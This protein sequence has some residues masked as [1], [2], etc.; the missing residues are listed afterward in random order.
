MKVLNLQCVQSHDFEGWFSSEDDF[1]SQLAHGLL[2]CPVCGDRQIHKMP[3]APRLNLGTALIETA[4]TPP[5]QAD[6]PAVSAP[7][8]QA[9]QAAWLRVAREAMKHSEDVGDA[10]AEEARR[11]HRG[12]APERG[13]RGHTS[14]AEA[15][16]LMEE[17]V[18]VM[19]L[20]A[21]SK[22]TLQ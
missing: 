21:L 20:P 14:V 9:W 1:Q 19:P 11:I 13:I 6:R 10:F 18:P 22:E 12:E 3:S 8:R 7:D 5:I 17:G 4:K 2:E 15:V 16:A